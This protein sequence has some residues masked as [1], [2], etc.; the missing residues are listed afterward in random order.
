MLGKYSAKITEDSSGTDTETKNCEMF[1]IAFV[2]IV[3]A[4]ISML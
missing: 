1:H 4:L 3:L 2:T